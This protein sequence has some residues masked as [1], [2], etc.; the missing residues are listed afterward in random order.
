[1]LKKT[2][3][4]DCLPL[5]LQSKDSMARRKFTL[6]ELLVVIAIIAILAAMLL[7]A[8]SAARERARSTK[9]VAQ[10]KDI[11]LAIHQYGILSGGM[12]FYS[13]NAASQS[14]SGDANGRYMWSAKLVAMGLLEN[15]N[16]VYCPT[17]Q[18]T[19]DNDRNYSYAAPY[20]TKSIFNLDATYY[21]NW[22]GSTSYSLDPT[23][24][25]LLGD[26]A[27]KSN[28]TAFYRMNHANG[29]DETY[30]RP[31]IVHGRLANL[32]MADGHVASANAKEL[33][34]YRG[35]VPAIPQASGKRYYNAAITHFYDP[36]KP[37]QYQAI[38]DL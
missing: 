18:R 35:P 26:G 6:I 31:N 32:V 29:T 8:L 33:A 2:L 38:A 28:G 19:K 7:P 5:I 10:L 21:T 16:V 3:K 30:A 4:S 11:A 12:Y 37:G 1:M 27:I 22:S 14:S 25:F 15:P 24:V 17:T 20:A 13:D 23:N 36:E 9:C 34:G